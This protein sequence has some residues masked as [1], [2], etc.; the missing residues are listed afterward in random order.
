MLNF[1][2]K[3]KLCGFPKDKRKEGFDLRI[4]QKIVWS[5][6]WKGKVNPQIANSNP[7]YVPECFKTQEMCDKAVDI[8]PSVI[9]FVPEYFKTK[10]V[11]NKAFPKDYFML[12]YALIF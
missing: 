12:K 3:Q 6:L 8:H 5:D 4:S 1:K 11:C 7:G 10:V 9:Q 2:C